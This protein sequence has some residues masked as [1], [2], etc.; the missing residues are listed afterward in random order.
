MNE[1]HY[2]LRGIGS[3]K[4]KEKKRKKKRKEKKRKQAHMNK[5]T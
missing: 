1:S 3:M 4:K 5:I 2:Y